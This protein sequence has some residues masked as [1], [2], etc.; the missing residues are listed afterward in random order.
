MDDAQEEEHAGERNRDERVEEITK[1]KKGNSSKNFQC[2][3]EC[4]VLLKHHTPPAERR[5]GSAP[6]HVRCNFV[7]SRTRR[8][9]SGWG[10][11]ES[12]RGGARQRRS[13]MH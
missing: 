12:G 7:A 2:G 5:R 6:R 11:A 8:V 3:T 4:R 10:R 1:R 9:L 13:A